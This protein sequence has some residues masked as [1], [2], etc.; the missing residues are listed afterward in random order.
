MSAI[1]TGLAGIPSAPRQTIWQLRRKRF[2]R[3]KPA[4][5]ALAILVTLTALCVLAYPYSLLMGLDPNETNLLMRFR[6]PTATHWLGTDSLGRDVLLRLMYGGQ[7]SIAVGVL[8]TLLT[9][10]IGILI[11]VW[12]G[13]LGGKVD[14]FLMRLTDVVIAL[15]MTPV[16][17][18]LGAVDLSK[19]GLSQ[20]LAS[21]PGVVFLRI[22]VIIALVDWTTIARITRAATIEVRQREYVKAATV[23]GA[24]HLYNVLV[25]VL[26]NITTPITVAATLSVGRIIL[27]ESTL[28]FLGFGIVPPTP[29]W[30]NMLTN[31]QE[32]I[33]SA[34]ALAVYPGLLIFL[35]VI[36]VNFVGDGIRIAFDP[37]S[38]K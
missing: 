20:A 12:A 25:H 18:V 32:L 9:A 22:V 29:S 13:F 5:I 27:F 2:L 34:P 10:L 35:T 26:P 33:I 16:L 24:R 31:A 28:S 17:I 11:G 30:G 23:S 15:P 6:P 1:D 4:V 21:S 19:L 7:V 14:A 8:G 38:E 3:N 37:R 36:S